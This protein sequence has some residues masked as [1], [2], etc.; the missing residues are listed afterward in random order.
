[1]TAENPR[2]GAYKVMMEKGIDLHELHA[3]MAPR[4]FLYRAGRRSAGAMG[5]A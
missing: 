3:L 2:T 4:P 5:G 1:V